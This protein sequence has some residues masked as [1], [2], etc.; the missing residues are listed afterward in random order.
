MLVIS[1][2]GFVNFK[3]LLKFYFLVCFKNSM[4][5]CDN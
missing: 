2:Y 1:K 5:E 4:I 3:C